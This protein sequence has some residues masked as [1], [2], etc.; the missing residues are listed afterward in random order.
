MT[1]G[2]LIKG[3]TMELDEMFE[4]IV[5]G[6]RKVFTNLNADVPLTDEQIRERNKKYIAEVQVSDEVRLRN[7]RGVAFVDDG[8]SKK[9][10]D[11]DIVDPLK[12]DW[13]KEYAR[14]GLNFDRK[15]DPND[16]FI[17]E[18]I[19]PDDIKIVQQQIAKIYDAPHTIVDGKKVYNTYYFNVEAWCLELFFEAVG[20]DAKIVEAVMNPKNKALQ[21]DIAGV[22]FTRLALAARGKK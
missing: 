1:G 8:Y 9:L 10:P 18:T 3:N 14:P 12:D 5:N 15:Y 6:E 20:W 11:I 2:V 22:G 16:F 4:K 21:S 7:A 17:K 19:A 13:A